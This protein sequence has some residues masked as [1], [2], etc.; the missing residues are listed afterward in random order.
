MPLWTLTSSRSN[1]R[2][3]SSWNVTVRWTWTMSAFRTTDPPRNSTRDAP[4]TISARKSSI[5]LSEGST[6]SFRESTPWDWS[7]CCALFGSLMPACASNAS[8]SSIA[9]AS[10][11]WAFGAGADA[12]ACRDSFGTYV[13]LDGMDR[14]AGVEEPDGETTPFCGDASPRSSWASSCSVRCGLNEEHSGK[15][16]PRRCLAESNEDNRIIF[17]RKRSFCMA[18]SRTL[19]STAI[20]DDNGGKCGAPK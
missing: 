12:K 17:D 11:V 16:R 10:E 6:D 15:T 7:T 8:N 1:K 3:F 4:S 18:R 9:A 20:L 2:C 14:D 5:A 19:S 13:G